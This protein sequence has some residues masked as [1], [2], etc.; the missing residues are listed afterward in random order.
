MYLETA[1]HEAGNA[2]IIVCQVQNCDLR[3]VTNDDNRWQL[4]Q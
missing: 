1:K 3:I 2:M 4:P